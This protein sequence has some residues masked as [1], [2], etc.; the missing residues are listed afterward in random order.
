LR[1]TWKPGFCTKAW[2]YLNQN[3]G[4]EALLAFD[5]ATR[6]NDEYYA[7][8]YYKAIIFEQ[9]QELQQALDAVQKAIES[10]PSF[11]GS[12]ELAARI[13]EKA[14]DQENAARY[15]RAAQQ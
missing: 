4:Q 2:P 7:A 5:E 11:K 6:I 1:P 13:F 12:Y 10:N 15:R 9:R 3:K 14:G 8:Y